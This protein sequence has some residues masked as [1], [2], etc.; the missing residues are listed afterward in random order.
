[1]VYTRKQGD[2]RHS[3]YSEV[4]KRQKTNTLQL[5]NDLH[6]ALSNQQFKVY[7]QPIVNLKTTL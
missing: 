1:M 4:G 7:Y 3:F 6:L 2:N 5:E